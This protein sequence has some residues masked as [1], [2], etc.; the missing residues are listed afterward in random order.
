MAKVTKLNELIQEKREEIL[1]LAAKHGARNVRVFGSV[2]RNEAGPESDVDFLI[3][4]GPKRT[5]WFPGGLIIDLENLLGCKVD[6]FTE[7]GLKR[8]IRERILQEAVPL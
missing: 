1:A 5:P 2:A 6:V 4:L 7:K 8:R 3:D